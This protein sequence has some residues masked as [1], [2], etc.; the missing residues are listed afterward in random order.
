[1]VAKLAGQDGW[2]YRL[3]G[4]QSRLIDDVTGTL[5]PYDRHIVL[6]PVDADKVCADIEAATG[7]AAAVVDANDLGRVDL[8]GASSSVD[9]DL[10][11]EA[12]RPNPAGNTLETTPIVLIRR[13]R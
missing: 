5:A 7:L 8:V 6:G 11:K 2:F 9:H 13:R 12:L 1:M 10:V 4:E 3:T